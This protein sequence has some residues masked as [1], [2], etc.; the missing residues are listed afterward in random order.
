MKRQYRYIGFLC[1]VTLLLTACSSPFRPANESGGKESSSSSESR[2]NLTLENCRLP[3]V[4]KDY[5]DLLC[6]HS[7]A[8]FYLESGGQNYLEFWL[9]SARDLSEETIL[10]ATE[11]GESFEGAVLSSSQYPFL[12]QNFLTYQDFD[13][14]ELEALQPEEKETVLASYRAVYDKIREEKT[15]PYLYMQRIA[16]SFGQ[17]GIEQ[18]LEKET[19]IPPVT[20]SVRGQSKTYSLDNVTFRQELVPFTKSLQGSLKQIS[21]GMTGVRADPT[22]TGNFSVPEI[23]L[24]AEKA[25]TLTGLSFLD[26]KEIRLQECTVTTDTGDGMVL[27]QT[28]DGA[29]PM[30]IPAGASVTLTLKAED[31]FLAGLLEASF[32]RYLAV[33][34]T[35]Q[36]QECGVV[37]QLYYLMT[38]DPF[39]FYAMKAEGLEI[40]PW[41]YQ[42]LVEEMQ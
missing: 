37:V 28:W 30:D 29:S 15:V 26:H 11:G 14:R 24:K 41:Q 10:F 32:L 9:L 17:L 39:D 38:P 35:D 18:P 22:E 20:V 8:I 25:V 21:L 3:Q 7:D 13:W 42:I 34:Y 19:G 40:R 4:E 23:K 1:M 5:F 33:E 6:G 2:I 27:N 31:P 12:F 36:G 16:I